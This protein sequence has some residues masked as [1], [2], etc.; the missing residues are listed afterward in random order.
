MKILQL[1]VWMRQLFD[2]IVQ[3]IKNEDP[4]VIVL[5]EVMSGE[6]VRT[7]MKDWH[8]Q[9]LENL[10]YQ[11]AVWKNFSITH[12]WKKTGDSGLAILS[13]F[14]IC[15]WSMS[16]VPELWPYTEYEIDRSDQMDDRGSYERRL[17]IRKRWEDKPSAI[18]S[19]TIQTPWWCIRVMT[20][21]LPA[22]P[23]CTD[24]YLM[25]KHAEHMMHIYKQS[26]PLPTV[27]AW[28]FNT[29]PWSWTIEHIL[30]HEFTSS[31]DSHTNTLNPRIH[32][33]FKNDIPASWYQVDHI[34]VVWWIFVSAKTIDIDVSDHLPIVADLVFD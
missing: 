6:I 32:P 9:E 1:N 17:R 10:W 22:S 29:K 15:D 18:L 16:F 25:H 21:K 4:D 31:F 5:Q 14:D 19:A 24:T 28:D 12:R 3:F 34:L 8:I 13:K 11:S 2:D 20:S 26:K 27:I 33:W 23:K 7:D 30:W